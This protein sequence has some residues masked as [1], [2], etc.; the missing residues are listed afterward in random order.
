MNGEPER[1]AAPRLN[2][3]G[4]ARMITVVLTLALS[5]TIFFLA[6][7]TFRASRGWLY[8]GGL[9]AYLVLAMAAV[10]RFFPEVIE[11]INARGRFNK[12]VKR[13]DKFFALCYTV[14]ALLQPAVAGWDVRTRRSFEVPWL[15]AALGLAVTILAYAFIHWAMIVNKHAETGVRIQSERHHAVVSSGPY[16]IVRHPF[17][18]AA[19]VGHLIYP[20]AL[21]SPHAWIPALAMALLIL[22]RTAREDETLRQELDGYEAFA[23][24]TR[25]RLV[26]GVW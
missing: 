7:G 5:A 15:V 3:A 14:L 1:A 21:G 23:Q 25:Y 8:Y 13:W 24:R 2:R 9:L 4:I 18:I 26:P 10:F 16:R 17:Y 11:T 19:I 12:D 22:W 20:L 6:A